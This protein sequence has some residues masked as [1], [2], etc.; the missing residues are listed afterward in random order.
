MYNVGIRIRNTRGPLI[1]Q[2]WTKWRTRGGTEEVPAAGARR[3]ARSGGCRP[4]AT[5]CRR[6]PA[7]GRR[8]RPCAAATAASLGWKRGLRRT[9]CSNLRAGTSSPDLEER[10]WFLKKKQRK[11]PNSSVRRLV[12][13]LWRV[14]TSFEGPQASLCYIPQLS[15]A[16]QAHPHHPPLSRN[17]SLAAIYTSW[18][19]SCLR[20]CHSEVRNAPAG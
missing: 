9:G 3:G 20:A 14:R 7:A 18:A 5:S 13:L 11:N 6:S 1:V 19:H 17:S 4:A 15:S 16:P 10:S 2:T 8:A 12:N